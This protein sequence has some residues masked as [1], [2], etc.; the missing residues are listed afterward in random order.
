MLLYFN[1]RVNVDYK[2][3]NNILT[4]ILVNNLKYYGFTQCGSN[5]A[6][7]FKN[8]PKS[9]KVYDQHTVY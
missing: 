6:L 7:I 8:D 3:V 1:K 9:Q 5:S 4:V 2:L